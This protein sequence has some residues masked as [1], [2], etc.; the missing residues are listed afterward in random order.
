VRWQKNGS[1]GFAKD[2]LVYRAKSKEPFVR[3][4][5]IV[6]KKVW[7]VNITSVRLGSLPTTLVYKRIIFLMFCWFIFVVF[8]GWII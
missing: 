4:A 7:W 2:R 8:V 3:L 5:K 1:F 6:F